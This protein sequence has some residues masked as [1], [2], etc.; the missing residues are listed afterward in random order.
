M[1]TGVHRRTQPR[2]SIRSFVPIA[3]AALLLAP[4]LARASDGVLEINQ[5]CALAGCF[6]GDAAGYPVTLANDG[7]Y[8]LTSSLEPAG[9]D[10]IQISTL[11]VRID[12]NG[13]TIQG[14]GDCNG[15]GGAFVSCSGNAG[16]GVNAD[17]GLGDSV[18][19]NVRGGTIRGMTTGIGFFAVSDAT[20]EDLTIVECSGNGISLGS[21]VARGLTLKRNGGDGISIFNLT[22]EY[23]VRDSDISI[24][25]GDGISAGGGTGLVRDNL[26][27]DNE[28]YGLVSEFLSSPTTQPALAG[29]NFTGNDMGQVRGGTQSGSNFCSPSGSCP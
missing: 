29:N 15:T 17:L 6:P 2:R 19:A 16:I 12:L 25:G 28:G 23:V 3:L 27:Y 22:S 7:S 11:N 24:N 26:V 8:R 1:S 9:A 4:G 10:G 20:L 14:P 21:G 5:A 13:F 18:V